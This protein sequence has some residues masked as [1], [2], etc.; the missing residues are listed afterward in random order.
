M[1][2]EELDYTTL[3]KIFYDE[4]SQTPSTQRFNKLLKDNGVGF[5][6]CLSREDNHLYM[7]TN[8]L[9]FPLFKSRYTCGGSDWVSSQIKLL[10]LYKVLKTFST[11]IE[12]GEFEGSTDLELSFVY[13]K[14]FN[15]TLELLDTEELK[16]KVAYYHNHRRFSLH[17]FNLKEGLLSVYSEGLGS[18]IHFK[19]S[20]EDTVSLSEFTH[21]TLIGLK[22]K[23]KDN[24]EALGYKI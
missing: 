3:K 24:M 1:L 9:K 14:K 18:V 15:V 17:D 2:T 7:Y 23:V 13:D 22:N 19:Y 6:V 5:E 21:S 8:F 12:H 20:V 4:N 10:P 11:K 16:I